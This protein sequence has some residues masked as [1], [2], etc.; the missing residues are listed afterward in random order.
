MAMSLPVGGP[1]LR[2]LTATEA[3]LLWR[4]PA[5]LFWGAG[6]PLVGLLVLGLIPGTNA[7][8]KSF[9]GASVLQT[10]LPIVIAFTIVMT[11]VNFLPVTLV[12]YRERGILRRMSTTPVSPR[13]VLGAQ[14]I[15]NAS[16]QIAVAVVTVVIAVAGFGFSV[17]QPLAFAVAFV[18]A[19]MALNALGLLVAAVSSTGKAASAVGGLLFFVLMFLG[20]LW[21]PRSQMPGALRHVS[22]VS[23]VGAAVQ[24]LQ[25]ATA[26]HWAP[27]YLAVLAGYVIICG[28]LA[29]RFFRWE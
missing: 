18:L 2:K 20:G 5:A 4:T 16:V 3:K 21:W 10:Y 8:V 6:F 29:T 9:G 11:A 15:V 17:R 14:L 22:D 1:A 7:P 12:T 19:T 26:G 27:L 23:P 28:V 24:G 25:D 13:A